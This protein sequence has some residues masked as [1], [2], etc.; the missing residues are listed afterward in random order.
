MDNQPTEKEYQKILGFLPE[1]LRPPQIDD[2]VVVHFIACDNL[3]TRSLSK[4]GKEELPKIAKLI[5]GIPFTLDHEWGEVEEAQG[6]CFDASVQTSE[7][8]PEMID[9]A[10]NGIENK[11]IIEKEGYQYVDVSV[12]FPAFSPILEALRFGKC[13]AVSMGGFVYRERWCPL[14]E[15]SFDDKK[16]P[17]F[18]PDMWMYH[19][20]KNDEVAPYYIRRDIFDLGELSLVLIPNLPNARVK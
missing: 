16:C 9:K 6:L 17:H 15:C 1:S 7:A 11:N 18:I 13:G 4:W 3:L 14:C 10:G 2:F 5:Q 12:A 19:P 20:N 8:T